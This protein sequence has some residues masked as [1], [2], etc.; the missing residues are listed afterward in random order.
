MLSHGPIVRLLQSR[1]CWVKPWRHFLFL[2]WIT[3]HVI[4]ISE[5]RH[6]WLG[7]LQ[8]VHSLRIYVLSLI[9]IHFCWAS[10]LHFTGSQLLLSVYLLILMISMNCFV[11]LLWLTLSTSTAVL[12]TLF[13]VH[14]AICRILILGQISGILLL[15][16]L[17]HLLLHF[18]TKD[19]RLFSQIAWV[20]LSFVRG[21][22]CRH[23]WLNPCS[24]WS[25]STSVC[26]S[27]LTYFL[28]ILECCSALRGIGLM[29]KLCLRCSSR[30]FA[31]D[32]WA[33]ITVKLLHF[34][35]IF[36]EIRSTI[37]IWVHC[38]HGSCVSI[39]WNILVLH[40]AWKLTRF[41]DVIMVIKN[42]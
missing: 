16:L 37:I 8:N 17:L 33:R 2:N 38:C 24:I 7:W 36:L 28:L 30:F 9:L 6:W 13:L 40:M 19:G 23:A 12:V 27:I 18:S 34:P 29:D 26:V 3:F 41:F 31:R 1:A 11:Y 39:C 14:Q 35:W 21:I 25:S 15:F 10:T 42:T 32:R 5:Y 20:N 22:C 4:L